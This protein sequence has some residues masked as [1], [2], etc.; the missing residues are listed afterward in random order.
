MSTSVPVVVDT[1]AAIVIKGS[2]RRFFTKRVC[3]RH[4]SDDVEDTRCIFCFYPSS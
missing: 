1:P 3:Y 2:G 4:S